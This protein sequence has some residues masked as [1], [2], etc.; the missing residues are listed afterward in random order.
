MFDGQI[1]YGDF[2]VITLICGITLVVLLFGIT[3]VIW[4]LAKRK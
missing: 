3:A 2:M 1:T 4:L